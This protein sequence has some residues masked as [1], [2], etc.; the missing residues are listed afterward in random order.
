MTALIKKWFALVVAVTCLLT[1]CTVALPVDN[2][3]TSSIETP[4]FP[5]AA[6][7][8]TATLTPTATPKTEA[9]IIAEMEAAIEQSVR[10]NMVFD[11]ADMLPEGEEADRFVITLDNH[12][13][14]QWMLDIRD[15]VASAL[16]AAVAQAEENCSAGLTLSFSNE[17]T[18]PN[19]QYLY[20]LMCLLKAED[21]AAYNDYIKS[22][23]LV[24]VSVESVNGETPATVCVA[25]VYYRDAY[26]SIAGDSRETCI[27]AELAYVYMNTVFDENIDE[28][29]YVLPPAEGNLATGITWPLQ[30]FTRLR[31]NWYA[32]RDNGAR[33]HTGS[34]I[35]A[36]E[37]AEI[38][39]CTEGTVYYVGSTLKGG[40]IVVVFD[41][42]GYIF[43]YCH[44]VCL[45]DFLQEG[46][47]VEAGQLIGYVGN[48]GNSACNHLHLTIIAPDGILINP[49]TYLKDVKP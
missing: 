22:S 28:K 24:Q 46:Q 19:W 45:S 42:F 35:W 40:N 18:A 11:V 15:E 8:P 39:S 31:R 41:D 13:K 16:E 17:V 37:G 10:D 12:S 30:R 1:A 14:S 43:E 32:A 7:T 26:L 21:L 33:K 38:Y 23:L 6:P 9:Q 3:A 44:M 4:Q 20:M 27:M 25:P 36:P 29:K 34:D 5:T 2:P 49:Y 47:R 48:T